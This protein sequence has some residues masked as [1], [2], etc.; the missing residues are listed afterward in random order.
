MSALVGTGSHGADI[1]AVADA[2]GIALD[3][4]DHAVVPPPDD[5]IDVYVGVND[6]KIRA[7]LAARYG[8]GR[9]L[10]HPSVVRGPNVHVHDG[11]VV[12]PNVVLLRD[13]VLAADVHVNYGVTMT[14]TY[15]GAHTTIAPGVT[16]CGDVQIGSEVFIGAGATICHL[17]RIG[18]RAV[19]GA[20]A[21]V[22]D[23]V[24]DDATVVGVPAK[25]RYAHAD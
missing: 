5:L 21:V 9:A 4:Y 20:G 8:L 11:C 22:L 1:L 17:V 15:V 23:D 14:R 10:V 18:D 19:I 16:I 6:P 25:V 2:C 7:R 3:L 13:V 24:A 12:A